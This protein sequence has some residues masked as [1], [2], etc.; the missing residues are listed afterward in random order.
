MLKFKTEQNRVV[1]FFRWQ[2]QSIWSPT[3]DYR[4]NSFSMLKGVMT[5]Q[6][7]Y[8]DN[9]NITT[10]FR[11]PE[12]TVLS[13]E[14]TPTYYTDEINSANIEGYRVNFKN[15][16]RGS[17]VNERT[18]TNLYT[19]DGKYSED[20]SIRFE[21]TVSSNVYNVRIIRLTTIIDI[22][23]QIL[24]LLAGLAFISRFMKFLL[25]KCNVWLHLDRE[26]NI[27]FKD[28]KRMSVTLNQ[29]ASK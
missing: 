6:N 11:G 21:T 14:L 10:A 17:V 18:L 3:I 13:F 25:M 12:P 23:T 19:Y 22:S 24:G 20:F 27:Y 15:F 2:F 4:S 29:P 7:L 26:Y 1:H 16:E 5:P 9:M 28:D 8:K